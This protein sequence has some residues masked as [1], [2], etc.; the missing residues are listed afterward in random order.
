MTELVAYADLA[1]DPLVRSALAGDRTGAERAVFA[2]AGGVPAS[3]ARR[4]L[5]STGPFA[6]AARSGTGGRGPPRD[7]GR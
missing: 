7:R 4:V 3:V 2:E 6:R 1:D 5:A